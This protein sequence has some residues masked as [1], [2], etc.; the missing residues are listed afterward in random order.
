MSNLAIKVNYFNYLYE[1][2]EEYN[3][4]SSEEEIASS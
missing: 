3:I 4:T 1:A 2:K